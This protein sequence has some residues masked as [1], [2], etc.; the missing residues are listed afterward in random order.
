LGK[1]QLLIG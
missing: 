1:A